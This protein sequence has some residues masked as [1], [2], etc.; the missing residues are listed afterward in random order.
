MQSPDYLQS[1]QS[2]L[3]QAISHSCQIVSGNRMKRAC[4]QGVRGTRAPIHPQLIPR[5]KG[6]VTY[7]PQ[8]PNWP[9]LSASVSFCPYC[10]CF[11][12][13]WLFSQHVRLSSLLN[14][15]PDSGRCFRSSGQ[16]LYSPPGLRIIPLFC[17]P[18][19]GCSKATET[20]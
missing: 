15:L 4:A 14:V 2:C 16:A 7:I 17:Y 1:C 18:L 20:W 13:I 6:G 8:Q 3:K 19:H 5:W 11:Q 9:G 12:N 10:I